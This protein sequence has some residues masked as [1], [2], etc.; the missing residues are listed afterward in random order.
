MKIRQDIVGPDAPNKLTA[1][2]VN[3]QTSQVNLSWKGEFKAASYNVYRS[4]VR[5]GGYVKIGSTKTTSFTDST[6]T[7]GTTYYYVV[8]SV[9][10]LGNEGENSKEANAT[11]AFPIGY[12]VLQYPK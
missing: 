2:A 1:T 6:V 7:N 9:D 11:P 8:R 12:A 5:G 3:G 4:P 10:G